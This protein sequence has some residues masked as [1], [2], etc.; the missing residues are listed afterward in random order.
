L[1]RQH[2]QSVRT[3][4]LA[5]DVIVGAI[6]FVA[7][8]ALGDYGNAVVLTKAGSLKVVVL[9]LVAAF[10]WPLAL[11]STDVD[12]STRQVRISSLFGQ[13]FLA[14]AIATVVVAATA[15][16]LRVPISPLSVL[17]CVLAQF[18]SV[19]LF[20]LSIFATLRLARRRGRNF[21][22]LLIV[23]SGPRA[24]EV[25]R[26]VEQHPE[27]GY[28]VIGFVDE[29]GY[30][31]DP[32]IPAEK[33]HKFVDLPNLIREQV[34]DEVIT[35]CP[36]S[37][38]A[39]LSPVVAICTEVGLPITLL[40]DLFGDFLP[41]PKVTRFDTMAALNFSPVH[42]SKTKLAVKRLID[43]VGSSV[44][45][46]LSA[47]L[48]ALAAIAIKLTSPGPVLFRQNRCG[49]NGRRFEMLKLRTMVL[50]AE[51]RKTAILD[52]NEMD[53]PV[54]KIKNDPRVTLV[55]AILRRWS[56]D[57]LPQIW[58]VLR[59]DMSLVGPRPPIPLEVAHYETFERRRLS[60]R[61]GLTCLWQ[62][63]GRNLVSFA[64]WVKL[65]VEYIDT[66]S[67]TNDFKILLR[68]IPTVLRG[69]GS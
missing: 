66:W 68:T 62:V 18:I 51:Q 49:L 31:V 10:V 26:L 16:A 61:P 40:S 12:R 20:R 43:V 21:R 4:V 65:D 41:P 24:R 6:A 19:S 58:N 30:P 34:I 11:Q 47:P 56:I 63:S 38:F 50:D 25:D 23:G 9:G 46:T 14:G 54:F 33:V 60:M 55:G 28:R 53:G 13:L 67:L 42:H 64:D 15:F 2:A 36:R 17:V 5:L 69:T 8:M 44:L 37:V 29:G 39:S 7:A 57:E 3:T 22:N 35:A 59:G 32:S 45:L 52:L 1:L 48:T 27:W